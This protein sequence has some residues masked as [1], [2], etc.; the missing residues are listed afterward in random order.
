MREPRVFHQ[1]F[2]GHAVNFR[3]EFSQRAIQIAGLIF[4]ALAMNDPPF[5][6]QLG[7]FLNVEIYVRAVVN[8]L[9]KLDQVG[10]A[11]PDFSRLRNSPIVPTA[12]NWPLLMIPIRSHI[13]SAI[14][15]M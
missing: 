9:I 15:R 12:I 10:V 6:F 8:C 3:R 13:R 4:V 5:Q 7:G 14:S 1:S 11:W 2:S